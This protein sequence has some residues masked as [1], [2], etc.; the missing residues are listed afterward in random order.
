MNKL[1]PHQ[2]LSLEDIEGEI[3]KDIEGYDGY[4]QISNFGR[5]KSLSRDVFNGMGYYL[6]KEKILKGRITKYGYINI[7]ITFN[8]KQ[9]GL[10]IHRVVAQHFINN[11]KNKREVNHI[12]SIKLNNSVDNLEWV[13]SLENK[14]HKNKFTL[15]K[16][17][18]K[19]IGVALNKDVKTKKWRST[20]KI[21]KKIIYLGSYYTEEEAYQRRCEYE[22]ANNIE[23]KYL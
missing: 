23:N 7:T 2:N 6:K 14:C 3:W 5:V 22:K 12:D 21:K 10:I 16:K 13:S 17:T 15:N 18:S 20:I 11:L 19:Y 9:Y 8:A 4:Y 1:L